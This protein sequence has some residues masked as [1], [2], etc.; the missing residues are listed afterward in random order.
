MS[1][2][3]ATHQQQEGKDKLN[4]VPDETSFTDQKILERGLNNTRSFFFQKK[5]TLLYIPKQSVNQEEKGNDDMENRRKDIFLQF[6]GLRTSPK[7]KSK[8]I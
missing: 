8:Q 3:T 5:N 1:A 4:K 7:N 6:H 2:I